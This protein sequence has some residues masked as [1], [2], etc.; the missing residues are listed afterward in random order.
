MT[1]MRLG[2][3]L[4]VGW[5]GDEME[6]SVKVCGHT[7]NGSQLCDEPYW[8]PPHTWHIS[9][10]TG[11][12]WCSCGEYHAWDTECRESRKLHAHQTGDGQ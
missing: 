5:T 4:G 7:G 6:E 1:T 12:Q 3:A 8:M 10:A 2:D 9:I 11:D